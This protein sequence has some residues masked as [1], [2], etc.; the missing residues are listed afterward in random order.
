MEPGTLILNE[1]IGEIIETFD[2]QGK[3][4]NIDLVYEPLSSI[5]YSV[6]IDVMQIVNV[7]ESIILQ[8]TFHSSSNRNIIVDCWVDKPK[9]LSF[10]LNTSRMSGNAQA[11]SQSPET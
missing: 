5:P 1:T 10:H 11:M 9:T 8:A 7:L 3:H 2:V 6:N 4:Q